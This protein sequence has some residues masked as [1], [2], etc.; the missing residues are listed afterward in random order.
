MNLQNG[1]CRMADRYNVNRLYLNFSKC[2]VTLITYIVLSRLSSIKELGVNFDDKY[3]CVQQ[4]HNIVSKDFMMLR[5]LYTKC[6][7]VGDIKA[8]NYFISL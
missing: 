7:N 8:L 4:I 2:S 5:F 1:L 3:L 6:R